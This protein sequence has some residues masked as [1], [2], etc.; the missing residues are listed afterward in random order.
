M[1]AKFFKHHRSLI[2]SDENRTLTLEGGF[3][4]R[5]G[6]EKYRFSNIKVSNNNANKINQIGTLIFMR[7]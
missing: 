3:I 6:Y 4:Q 7:I 2:L 5:V 1:N